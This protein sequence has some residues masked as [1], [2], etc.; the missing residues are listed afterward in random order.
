MR[1]LS[2][3]YPIEDGIPKVPSSVVMKLYIPTDTF[4]SGTQNTQSR[5]HK[6]GIQFEI[7]KATLEKPAKPNFQL[8]YLDTILLY[9]PDGIPVTGRNTAGKCLHLNINLY[10]GLDA[11]ATG[12]L[13]YKGFPDLPVA[14]Y[15]GD[16]FGNEGAGGKRISID[17][18][19]LVLG[20]DGT[21]WIS[22]E[23]GKCLLQ[24][25]LTNIFPD[26]NRTIHLSV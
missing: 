1:A 15:T 23:Y 24:I 14:T 8:K 5:I 22:D 3:G 21:F 19:G 10:A 18:E 2:T 4:F 6:F 17:A 16:G 9:G 26:R 11:D 13:T 25:Q 7:V 20:D 12:H